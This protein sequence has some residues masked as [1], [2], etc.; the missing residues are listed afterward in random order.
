MWDKQRSMCG[1]YGS[2]LNVVGGGL[3]GLPQEIFCKYNLWKT[4]FRAILK[5]LGKKAFHRNWEK[6]VFAFKKG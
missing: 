1:G 2:A 4:H 5:A 6:E 3:E